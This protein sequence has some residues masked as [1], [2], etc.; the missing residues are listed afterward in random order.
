MSA[1]DLS[2]IYNFLEDSNQTLQNVQPIAQSMK[3]CLSFC[4]LTVS[5]QGEI[6]SII[7]EFPGD[8]LIMHLLRYKKGP[9]QN[10]YCVEYLLKDKVLSQSFVRDTDR[11]T[12]GRKGNPISGVCIYIDMG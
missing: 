7:S 12:T 10:K 4:C 3:G 8:K 11:G 1:I 9:C 6:P 2:L 5:R